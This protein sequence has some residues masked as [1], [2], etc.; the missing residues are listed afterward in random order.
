MLPDLY[1]IRHGETVW[2]REGRLQGRDDSPLTARGRA[3]ARAVAAAA[4]RIEAECFCSPQ[5]RA[6]AT[7]DLVFRDRPC[8]F[9]PRLAEIDTGSFTGRLL[10]EIAA[11]DPALFSARG[12]GW[13]DHCPGGEGFAALAARCRSFLADLQGPALVIGHGITLRMIWALATG[14][15]AGRL[16]AAPLEQGEILAIPARRG[17]PPLPRR[18]ALAKVGQSAL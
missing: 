8:R 17:V 5:G 12:L 1:L 6:R 13:Y 7:A 16:H 18:D 11:E 10:R 4:A 2:N 3:Q 9:D 14:A 15:G